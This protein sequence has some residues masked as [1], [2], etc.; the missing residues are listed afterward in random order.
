MAFVFEL[1]EIGEGV[2]EGEVVAWKVA[3]GERVE[4]DAPLCEIMTDKATVEISSPTSGVLLRTYGEPGDIIKVHTPLAEIDTSGAGA[5]PS[6]PPPAAAPAPPPAAPAPVAAAPAPAAAPSSR[7]PAASSD[8]AERGHTKA[9]PAVRRD[10]RERGID[11][12]AVPGTGPGGRVT[13]DD[14]AAFDGAP[15]AA[16]FAPP[17][18][19]QAP[20][21]AG[22][23]VVKIIGLRRKIAQQMLAAKQSAPHFTYV[24]EIDATELVALRGRLKG[25]AAKRGVK[26]TYLPFILKALSVAFRDFPNVNATMNNETYELTVRAEHNIGVACDTPAGLFVPV[27]KR[28]QHKSI[29]EIAAELDALTERTRA[30]KAS[31]DDLSGGT[32]TVTSVGNIGGMLATPILNVPEVA[33]LGVNAIRERAV[34]RDGEIVVRSM[35]YLSPSFDHRILDGAVAARFVARLKELLEDPAALLVELT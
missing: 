30:G 10:A 9:T 17:A 8:P 12:H 26:L 31:L 7:R 24:E 32:F 4:R 6:A 27:L 20:A 18:L 15:A 5:A 35:L 21:I 13:R 14:L 19:P 2:V 11:I 28:V 23:Q 22:D 34:V 16:P 3:I 25:M 1:P 33:I 29:L